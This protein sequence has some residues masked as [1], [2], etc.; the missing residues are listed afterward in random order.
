[1]VVFRDKIVTWKGFVSG[2]WLLQIHQMMAL[3]ALSVA[4]VN[5]NDCCS[6]EVIF[7]KGTS[8]FVGADMQKGDDAKACVLCFAY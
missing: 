1:V 6:L 3:M 2:V 4:P 5:M 7:W 8:G